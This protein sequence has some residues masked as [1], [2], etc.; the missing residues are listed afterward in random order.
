MRFPVNGPSSHGV[1]SDERLRISETA[2]AIES[3]IK[4]PEIEGQVSFQTL[5]AE[6]APS[7]FVF[8]PGRERQLCKLNGV[9][10]TLKQSLEYGV[11]Y[12]GVAM[13]TSTFDLK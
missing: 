12:S 8:K 9:E 11:I 10:N 13:K 6:A 7:V 5:Y 3:I 2:R 1:I 4:A